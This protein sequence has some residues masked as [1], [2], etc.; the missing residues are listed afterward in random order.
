MDSLS[1]NTS[2]VEMWKL[3]DD[4]IQSPYKEYKLS[5]Y[6]KNE[7]EFKDT[8]KGFEG[9]VNGEYDNITENAFYMVGTI[10]EALEK[11]KKMEEDAA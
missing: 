9:L 7:E 1:T 11:A 2:A 8:I 3:S 6:V 4:D 10:E 5:F